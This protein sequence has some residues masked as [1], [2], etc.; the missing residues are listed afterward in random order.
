M[1]QT[2]LEQ[3]SKEQLIGLV[4]D[5]QHQLGELKRMVFGTKSERF[6][7]DSSPAQLALGFETAE[8]PASEVVKEQ[9]TYSR[10]KKKTASSPTGR[11]PIPAHL[12]RKEIIIEPG[13]DTTGLKKIGEEVTEQLEYEPGKLFVNK[14][15]RPKYVKQEADEKAKVL[16]GRLP[17]FPIEKGI[18]GPGLLSQIIVDKFSDHLP[19]YRQIKRYQ[20]QG[21]KLSGSTINGWLTAACELL[22]PLYGALKSEV[23]NSGYLQADETPI[24]VLDKEGKGSTHQGYHWLYHSP[25]KKLVFFDY[26]AGRSRE[27]PV[28]ILKE[29]TG[30][31]QT[32]GY[33][34]YEDK[35]TG[36][37]KGIILMHCMAHARRYFEKALDSDKSRA[38]YFLTEV[39]KLYEIERNLRKQHLPAEEATALR[40]TE[41]VPVLEGLHVW[42]KEEYP[43][44]LPKGPIGKAIA[45]ALP[46]WE[47]LSVYT[48]NARLQ[49]DNNLIEN[50]VRPVALG[51]KNYLFAGSHEGARR[52]ALIYSLLGSCKMH[53][54]NPF[55]YLRDVLN[56]L[57]SYPINRIKE[58]LPNHWKVSAS[59]QN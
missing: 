1:Q 49:I 22:N 16:I 14:Y 26:R 59:P 58:L 28:E 9:I 31:L 3:L 30:Y 7:S 41:A 50:A 11:L 20:R 42:M 29:Y 10:E 37:K 12:E 4:I 21:V 33:A 25:E 55:E 23:L 53:E 17:D 19:V 32:D 52:A 45:Y 34:A 27:G 15:V 8:Q 5:L 24:P 2:S 43:K 35:Q 44:L 40:H 51:R 18:P 56:R 48:K 6:I 47:R 39:Q 36:N 46:R 38:E 54:V 57:P 13:D